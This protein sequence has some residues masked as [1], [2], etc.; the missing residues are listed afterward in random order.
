MGSV[1]G[2]GSYIIHLIGTNAISA[3]DF[4]MSNYRYKT[5]DNDKDS[6]KKFLTFLDIMKTFWQRPILCSITR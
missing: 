2:N 5:K 6:Y 1:S 4:W 3:I